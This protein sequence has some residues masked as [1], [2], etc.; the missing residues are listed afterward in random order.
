MP[1]VCIDAFTDLYGRSM[2]ESNQVRS[3][4]NDYSQLAQ[5]HRCL[6]LF[7]HHC[8]K[9]TEDG[10]PSKHN[11]LGSQ[12]FEAKMR[13]VMEL[14]C[15]NADKDLRH[16]CI[17]KGNY[18]PKEYKNES[19]QLWFNENMTF[20]NTGVR[21]PFEN[22]AKTEDTGKGKYEQIKMYQSQGLSM[23]EIAQEL[24]YKNKSSVSRLLQKH[25]SSIVALPLHEAT[26]SNEQSNKCKNNGEELPY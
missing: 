22:L 15:D 6:I 2:N 1:I 12:A 3:F 16:L 4:L 23:E 13:L 18:L 17:V 14:R 21:I 9:R 10:E 5:K 26:K 24:G 11:L 20:E 19:Y 8:G 7:L 25:E